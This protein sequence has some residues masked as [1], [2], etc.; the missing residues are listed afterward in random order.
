L[1]S[2][3]LRAV[4]CRVVAIDLSSERAEKAVEFGAHLGLSL[5]DPHLGSNVASFSRYGVDAAIITAATKS[6]EPLELA[7]TLLRDRGR[8][9]VVGDVGMGVSRS[10]MYRK[11]ISLTMS[12]S[13][14]PGR[15]DPGYEEGGHD[16]PIGFVRW[17][18]KR[19]MEAFLDLLSSGAF[20][21]KALLEHM[22]AVED[23]A[24]AY[25]AVEGG[26]YTSIIDYHAS[27]DEMVAE[28]PSRASAPLQARPIGVIRIGC[29]GAGAYARGVIL[30]Q[31]RVSSAIKLQSIASSTGA[32]SISARSGF[33]FDTAESPSELIANPNVDAVFILTRHDSHAAFAKSAMDAGKAVF[34]EKPLAVN[35][36]QLETIRTAYASALAEGR[37]AF[38]MVGYNRRFSPLTEKLK[39]FFQGRCEA[40]LVNIRCN[41]GYIP[42][43]SWIQSPSQ[44]GR[45]IGELCHFVDWARAIIGSPMRKVTAAALPDASRYCGDNVSVM[46]EYDDRSIAN[47]TYVANGDRA[48][49]KELFE[50]FCEGGIARLDDFKTLLLTRNGKTQTMK[51]SRDKG[52]EQEIKLTL[53]A[54]NEGTGAPISFDELVEVSETTF[55]IVEALERGAP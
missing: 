54:M 23:G 45:I 32:A 48:A 7:A 46:I 1:T 31:L 40:M 5:S 29:I 14:G 6:A 25:T 18:E 19:N 52:H 39:A 16:Y 3:V 36:A 28:K 30:P 17:T 2:L 43:S 49:G 33:G 50:V 20:E 53:A 35:R 8:I 34:V 55:A 10:Q 26:A 38:L 27:A 24:R 44:G 47:M 11:E 42:P 41:A 22:Y 15:Y 21:V 9:S 4:G 51:G 12:R 13:Y 37:S